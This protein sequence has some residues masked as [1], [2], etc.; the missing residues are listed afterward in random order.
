GHSL[1][2]VVGATLDRALVDRT[3]RRRRLARL[4]AL[5]RDLVDALGLVE[6]LEPAL[7]DRVD[8][9]AFGER[10]ADERPRRLGEQDAAARAC[11]AEA[12]GPDDVEAVVALVAD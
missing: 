1:R 2:E 9:D 6:V 8:G 11:A 5:D 7:A 4:D 3:R 12:G 10:R